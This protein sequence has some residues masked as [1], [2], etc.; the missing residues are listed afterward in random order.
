MVDP[1]EAVVCDVLIIGCG[2][3]GATAALH[4]A[5]ESPDLRII[6]VTKAES[7]LES[8]TYYAQGGIIYRGDE[9]SPEQLAKDLLRAGDYMNNRQAVEI[10][11]VEGPQL[12]RELLIEKYQVPFTLDANHHLE[13]TR[14]AAHSTSRIL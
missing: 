12:V 13:R 10:L 1:S 11:A 5:E 2:I 14:E 4:L 9:D 7:P 6:L 8:N 3:A